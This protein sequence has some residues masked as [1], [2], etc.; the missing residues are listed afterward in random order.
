[1]CISCFGRPAGH[2]VG[3]F[4]V[5]MV[6]LTL[7]T[8]LLTYF[9]AVNR[10]D[11]D[12]IFPY[13]SDAGAQ[14]PESCVFGQL[15]NFGAFLSV[16]TVYLRYRLIGELSRD[17]DSILSKLNNASFLFGI[18]SSLGMSIVAN[19]QISSA[20]LPHLIGAFTCFISGIIYMWSQVVLSYRMYPL[21]NGVKICRYRTFLASLSLIC[22]VVC[23]TTGFIASHEFRQKYPDAVPPLH[24]KN[25]TDPGY[26]LHLISAL[27]EWILTVTSAFFLLTYA[28][29][30]EKLRVFVGV[31][32]LVNHLDEAVAPVPP[33]DHA[34]LIL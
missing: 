25:K 33:T 14:R 10:K 17:S 30:F 31:E 2:G 28:G 13:I 20:I 1:M 4:P 9:M 26:D 18:L 23:V 21:Y 16:V 27:C 24:W 15:L 32:P 29:D 7:V 22:F 8:L 12:P 5:L 19:F 34:R 3:H 6:L 11:V